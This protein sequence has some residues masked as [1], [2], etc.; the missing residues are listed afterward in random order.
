MKTDVITINNI[1]QDLD[2]V[3]DTTEK[4]GKETGLLDKEKIRLRLLA[5]ELVGMLR[6]IAGDIVA[7]YWIENQDKSFELYLTSDVALDQNMRKQIIDVSTSGTNSA[8]KGFTGKLREMIAIML[9]PKGD[10]AYLPGYTMD[11][12]GA[13][14][15]MGCQLGIDGYI[16]TMQQYAMAV[17]SGKDE[18]SREAWDE[19]EK[20]IIA[21]IADDVRVSVKGYHVEIVVVKSF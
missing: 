17:Q 10:D 21:S 18:K 9:L 12:M 19:L 20:S 5:E 1:E 7:D 14:S 15:M 6:G 4:I 16:W 3:L 8:V 13:S 2:K 11:F